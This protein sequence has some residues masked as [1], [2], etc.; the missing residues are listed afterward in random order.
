MISETMTHKTYDE[1]ET[2]RLKAEIERLTAENERMR[3]VLETIAG[4]ATDR[5][6]ALQARAALSNIGA[7]SDTE[8]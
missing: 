6:Q 7:A 8:R 5:L 4:G 1:R 3:R 2:E